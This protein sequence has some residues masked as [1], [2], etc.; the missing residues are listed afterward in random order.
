MLRRGLMVALTIIA[1]CGRSTAERPRSGPGSTAGGGSGGDGS[2]A[3]AGGV[4]AGD[5]LALSFRVLEGVTWAQ[6]PAKGAHV[7]VDGSGVT[8]EGVADADGRAVVEVGADTG[9]WDVTFALAGHA[10]VT[11]LGVTRSVAE[12]VTLSPNVHA[13]L[14]DGV[15]VSGAVAGRST[16]TSTIRVNGISERSYSFLDGDYLAK[17]AAP[18]DGNTLHLLITERED[19]DRLSPILNAMWLDLP[20]TG[21]DI[22]ADIVLPNPPRTPVS[23]SLVIEAPATGVVTAET[24]EP[25]PP[26]IVLRHLGRV[27]AVVGTQEVV[28]DADHVGRFEWRVDAL[29]G[30]MAPTTASTTLSSTESTEQLFVTTASLDEGR[31]LRVPPAEVLDARGSRIEDLSLTWSAPE[32]TFVGAS[33]GHA[34][35]LPGGWYVYSYDARAFTDHP[36]PKL[37]SAVSLADV[38]LGDDEALVVYAFAITQPEG[39]KPWDW[40]EGTSE[41][42]AVI[43]RFGTPESGGASGEA[44]A[45]GLAGAAGL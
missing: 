4:S 24:L 22:T 33:L 43:R 32:H 35:A 31:L 37:P 39:H 8:R 1:A 41:L 10:P 17:V 34:A 6:G 9:P 28:R 2:S 40:G 12:P 3:G 21:L 26:D 11:I 13:M 38:D 29:D 42:R 20:W 16:E 18:P 25:E 27:G 44:G 5:T 23:T 30:D 7:R 19:D 36:W 14:T 45:G 15:W